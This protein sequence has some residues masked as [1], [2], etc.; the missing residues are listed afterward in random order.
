MLV[1]K[2]NASG[3]VAWY[4]FLGG[5]GFETAR[6]IQQ[7]ADGGYIVAGFEFGSNIPTL[8]GKTPIN[9]FTA[10]SDMLVVKM[11]ASGSVAWYTFLGG[12]E[13]EQAYSI[14][15]TADGGYIVAGS[16]SADITS[17]QGKTPV[18]DFAGSGD[19]LVIKLKNDGTM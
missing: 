4:T 13:F 6:S 5:A 3:S 1:V 19:M 9:V 8:Q 18:N 12:T 2:L 10:G 15:Q 14:Q 16:A 11:N 17:L 7:T